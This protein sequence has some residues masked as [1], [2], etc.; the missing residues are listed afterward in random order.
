[1]SAS[2]DSTLALLARVEALERA[3][4]YP[5]IQSRSTNESIQDDQQPPLPLTQQLVVVD[6][7]MRRARLAVEASHTYSA[8]WAVVPQ[9]DYYT[10]PLEDR[11]KYL[12]APSIQYLCKSLLMENKKHE[13]KNTTAI[14]DDTESYDPTNPR[15]FLVILQYAATLDIAKTIN[16]LRSL[17][18]VHQ[19]LDASKFDLR[20]ASSQDNDF[21]T[22]YSHNSVTPFGL[23]EANQVPVILSSAVVP[24]RYIW[25]GGGATHV[26]LRVTVNELMRALPHVIVGDISRPRTGVVSL[27][28]LED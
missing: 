23:K 22:G 3:R 25:M 15:F 27:S 10:W 7:G 20:I 2:D 11:A 12:K 17:R 26:K 16:V 24:F 5:K 14:N 21:L 28:D 1:M 9:P 18:P 6:E 4:H 13:P 8:Q 19:R